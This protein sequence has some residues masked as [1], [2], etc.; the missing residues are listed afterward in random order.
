M[1]EPNRIR[2]ISVE[3]AL[4]V[5]ANTI[6]PSP[7]VWLDGSSAAMTQL[8]NQIRRV[9][10]YFRTALLTGERG[11]GEEA[12]AHI[13]HQLSPRAH[14]PFLALTPAEA[15]LRFGIEKLPAN[16]AAEGMLY[17]PQPERLPRAAQIAL[18][19]LLRER[20]SN[21]PRIV[22]FAERG[23]RP[24][25]TAAGFSPELAESL[26]ALRITLPSLRERQEDIPE[27]LTR[28]LQDFAALS[29]N[30]PPQ[31]ASNL[32]EAAV[33]LPWPGNFNQLFCAA[34]G[35]M[36]LAGKGA[37]VAADLEAVLGAIPQPAPS[38]R[39]EIRTVR[40]DDVIQEHIRAVLFACNGNKLRTAEV[41]G[42]SRST[43]YRML[44]VQA[45]PTPLPPQMAS[46]RLPQPMADGIP[47][48]FKPLLTHHV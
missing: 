23:L 43:L 44:E 39:R 42:I 19:R 25:V 3:T 8:R 16:L 36:D 10:P 14:D 33:Q 35:L 40:L 31:L 47:A 32:L 15:E 7:A 28:V 20:G 2:S 45:P 4:P 9:A 17:L 38:D 37:L 12:A 24:L 29:G 11:C 48:P 26:N 27:L 22:A 18:L 34:T 6:S 1:P 30:T 21:A 5:E 41:L 46:S 13:L